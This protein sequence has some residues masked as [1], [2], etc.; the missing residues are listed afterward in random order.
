MIGLK[1]W[2]KRVI[3]RGLPE[4]MERKF[5]EILDKDSE[6]GLMIANLTQTLREERKPEEHIIPGKQ[7]GIASLPRKMATPPS[8]QSIAA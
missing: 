4:G 2:M 8:L 3:C 1:S 6:A 7:S 5:S